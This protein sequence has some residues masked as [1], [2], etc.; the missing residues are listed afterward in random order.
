M[1]DD[2]MKKRVSVFPVLLKKK[3]KTKFPTSF[4]A[5]VRLS[6]VFQLFYVLL[7]HFLN[8]KQITACEC[9]FDNLVRSISSSSSSS[10]V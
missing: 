1:T 2:Y 3:K 5:I 9:H 7:I 4:L 6:R 8:R 10:C